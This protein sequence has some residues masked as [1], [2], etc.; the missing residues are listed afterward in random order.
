MSL[1]PIDASKPEF[2]IF[3]S[4]IPSSPR[5]PYFNKWHHHSFFHSNKKPAIIF[6]FSLSHSTFHRCKCYLLITSSPGHPIFKKH[7]CHW[8]CFI[9]LPI[10]YHY[11]TLYYTL[12]VVFGLF[13]LPLEYM[14]YKGRDLFVYSLLCFQC[15]EQSLAYSRYS[16]SIDLVLNEYRKRWSK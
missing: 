6:N 8:H 12:I 2:L 4:Q 1:W 9:L 7:H 10:T 15:L 14:L 3:P 5:L 13:S 11:W 16:I